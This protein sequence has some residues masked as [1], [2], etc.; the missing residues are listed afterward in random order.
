MA[1]RKTV[2]KTTADDVKIALVKYANESDIKGA[3]KYIEDHK[4]EI[5]KIINDWGSANT[6]IASAYDI[7]YK[8]HDYSFAEEYERKVE[9]I[10]NNALF[11]D[12]Y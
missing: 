9:S 6:Y 4:E 8:N 10:N 3:I 12:E 5:A 7:S 1:K 11:E 2:K